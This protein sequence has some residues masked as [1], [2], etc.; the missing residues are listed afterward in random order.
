MD[1]PR[2][3]QISLSFPLCRFVSLLP[4]A[5][6]AQPLAVSLHQHVGRFSCS[7]SGFLALHSSE[8]LVLSFLVSMFFLRYGLARF[9]VLLCPVNRHLFD[10][11]YAD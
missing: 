2:N 9:V 6:S 3:L 1:V 8:S 5:S 10:L 11:L 4:A 7:R